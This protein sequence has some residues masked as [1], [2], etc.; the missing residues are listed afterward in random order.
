MEPTI[1]ATYRVQLRPDFGFQA[2][3]DILAYLADLGVS[4]L[5]T[6]PYLQS[7][8]GSAHGY[9]VVDPNRVN[10]EL[11]GAEAHAR[12]CKT[13]QSAGLGHVIDV[14]P[15]HM[16]IAGRQN[17]WWWDVLE[18]GPSSRYATYFDVDWEASEE[19]WLNKVLLPVLGDHY[20]RILENGEFRLSRNEGRF[21]LHYHDHVFPIDPSSLPELLK[22]AA[23]S[24][25]SELLAFLAESHARLPRPTVTARQAVERRH[26]DKAVLLE[27]LSRLCREEP[28]TR[29]A[30]DDV[31]GFHDFPT[32][33]VMDRRGRI[34]GVWIGYQP[35]VED[36]MR[37][38]VAE[39]LAEG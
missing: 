17:P 31:V 32:T 35:G 28:A 25:G 24:C 36:N 33:L 11:G 38:L 27:L 22:R 37:Q 21:T 7:V 20:G 34:R 23:E 5:Y 19:R 26:R 18:N 1:T 8:S 29:S 2:A 13:V 6:S 16:A 14:V 10:E 30:I 12:M 9:D 3:T 15:N 39:L 4:H